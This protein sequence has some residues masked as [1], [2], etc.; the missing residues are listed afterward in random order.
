VLSEDWEHEIAGWSGA[1]LLAC[2][3][4]RKIPAALAAT[5]MAHAH[6]LN[7]RFQANQ[8]AP[9]QQP[10]GACEEVVIGLSLCVFYC[11]VQ[12]CPSEAN[13]HNPVVCR[14]LSSAQQGRWVSGHS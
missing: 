7:Y 2:Q 13:P 12:Q 3:G 9:N 4:G 11:V 5:L 10:D 14:R 6:P 1:Q 8:R